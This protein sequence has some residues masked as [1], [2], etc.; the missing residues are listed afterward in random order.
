MN[1]H[2]KKSFS[3]PPI[4]RNIT[5]KC[6]FPVYGPSLEAL[7]ALCVLS[8]AFLM[9]FSHFRDAFVVLLP[10]IDPLSEVTSHRYVR[11]TLPATYVVYM[12]PWCRLAGVTDRRLWIACFHSQ[13]CPNLPSINCRAAVLPS[14]RGPSIIR[15]G[16]QWH[17][18]WYCFTQNA[19]K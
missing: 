8:H 18:N 5:G 4:A 15:D 13:S 11:L 14:P 19:S 6:V 17:Q 3:G 2:V 9:P 16:W 1:N 10:R 7:F 12:S